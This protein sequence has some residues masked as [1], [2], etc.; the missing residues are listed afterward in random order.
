MKYLFWD[1]SEVEYKCWKEVLSFCLRKSDM[2]KIGHVMKEKNWIQGVKLY[3][4]DSLNTPK[5]KD[6]VWNYIFE[7]SLKNSYEFIFQYELNEKSEWLKN[8]L[9]KIDGLSISKP[10]DIDKRDIIMCYG[11]M[12]EEIRNLA[13]KI[14]EIGFLSFDEYDWDLELIDIKLDRRLFKKANIRRVCNGRGYVATE[15]TEDEIDEFNKLGYV[16][17]EIVEYKHRVTVCEKLNEEYIN[18]I[19]EEAE[20]VNNEEVAD[21]MGIKTFDGERQILFTDLKHRFMMCI[22][23]VEMSEI[24]NNK[25]DTSKWNLI[26]EKEEY[27][28]PNDYLLVRD[29]IN[30]S[31]NDMKLG[32][33]GI[34]EAVNK[35]FSRLNENK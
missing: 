17:N 18:I 1:L 9:K 28:A 15:L 14:V 33:E 13:K 26:S 29:R 23:E 35:F 22:N 12:S 24:Q 27:T 16:I 20:K 7:Y 2:Y 30:L 11:K 25:M 32:T 4:I 10:I 19:E 34:K 6:M 3:S 21:L 5:D 31:F 8:E